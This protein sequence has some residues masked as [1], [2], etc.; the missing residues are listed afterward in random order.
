MKVI[1]LT[2]DEATV[3]AEIAADYVAACSGILPYEDKWAKIVPCM[4]SFG[5]ALLLPAGIDTWNA[6]CF[7]C[8]DEKQKQGDG[9]MAD[10]RKLDGVKLKGG[11]KWMNYQNFRFHFSLDLGISSLVEGFVHVLLDISPEHESGVL[12]SQQSQR[13]GRLRSHNSSIAGTIDEAE[14]LLSVLWQQFLGLSP[15]H[16]SCYYVAL[17][18]WDQC[19]ADES[20]SLPSP[21]G[22]INA[23][24]V[25]TMGQ[26]ILRWCL[27]H[28]Y[29][30]YEQT[31]KHGEKERSMAVKTRFMNYSQC[32]LRHAQGQVNYV[33]RGSG[34]CEEW[35]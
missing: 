17:Q 3:I 22:Y 25:R 24:L 16:E 11:R 13:R 14:H 15:E 29:P 10:R 26:V 34:G 21:W 4:Q 33:R 20:P 23:E 30:P 9:P 32:C 2:K 5:R 8:D 35:V 12:D 31:R 6:V 1:C 28:L 18:F 19:E 27:K 7:T